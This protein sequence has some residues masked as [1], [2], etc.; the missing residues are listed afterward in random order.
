VDSLLTF[1][2][3]YLDSPSYQFSAVGEYAINTK[4]INA[5]VGMHPFE[6]IDK[7][8]SVI[9]LVGWVLTGD[10]GWLIVLSFRVSGNIDDPLIEAAE[11]GDVEGTE[12][13]TLLRLLKLPGTLIENPEKVIPGLQE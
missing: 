13:S 4:Q 8:V 1:D 7:A 10:Q 12:A 9:P 5:T 6:T 3:F 2:D 11:S